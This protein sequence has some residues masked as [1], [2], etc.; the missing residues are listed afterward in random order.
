[1]LFHY[2]ILVFR[3][4]SCQIYVDR[5]IL[6]PH[7]SFLS[8]LLAVY[9]YT[10]SIKAGACPAEGKRLYDYT[11]RGAACL[12]KKPIDCDSGRIA[13]G[14]VLII[15]FH[16]SGHCSAQLPQLPCPIA[17]ISRS[18]DKMSDFCVVRSRNPVS[19]SLL[20]IYLW[21]KLTLIDTKSYRPGVL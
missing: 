2:P 19:S 8:M 16:R 21:S 13:E 5:G 4:F 18:H 11:S 12:P 9:L 1:M 6:P 14:L 17:M 7:L 20:S 3:Q 10:C 15:Y